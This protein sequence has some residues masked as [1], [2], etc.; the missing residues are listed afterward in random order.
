VAASFSRGTPG[1]QAPIDLE[2][3]STGMPDAVERV[4]APRDCRR[5]VGFVTLD[6][7]NP[8]RSSQLRGNAVDFAR[9]LAAPD[10]VERARTLGVL[11]KL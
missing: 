3:V 5:E 11:H 6:L 7:R 4:V 8:D 10:P 2:A 1:R 9:H